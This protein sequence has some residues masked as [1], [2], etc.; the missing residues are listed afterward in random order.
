MSGALEPCGGQPLQPQTCRYT[1][2]DV[3]NKGRW[4]M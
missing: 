4:I 3:E 2:G 1:C